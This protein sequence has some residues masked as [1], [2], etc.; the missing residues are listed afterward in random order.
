MKYILI[1]ELYRSLYFSKNS[2]HQ[3]SIINAFKYL[4]YFCQHSKIRASYAFFCFVAKK[5]SVWNERLEHFISQFENVIK[6]FKY[7]KY[8]RGSICIFPLL[9]AIVGADLSIILHFSASQ[10]QQCEFELTRNL[11]STLRHEIQ[12]RGITYGQEAHKAKEMV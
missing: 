4:W 8:F 10:P 2:V 9:S 3:I 7:L 5:V 1:H 12:H 6:K 11:Q